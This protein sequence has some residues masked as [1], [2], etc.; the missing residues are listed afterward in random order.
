MALNMDQAVT[1]EASTAAPDDVA[2]VIRKGMWTLGLGFG[3]FLI[4]AAFAPLDEGVPSQA[5]VAVESQRK[6]VQHL[7]GGIVNEVLVKEGQVVKAGDVLFRLDEAS[8][9]ASHEAVRQRYLG[10]RAVQARLL[11]EQKGQSQLI[12][13]PDL[14]T[15]IQDPLISN[16]VNTQQALL[17][18]RHRALKAELQGIEESI[19]G[20]KALIYSYVSMQRS[21]ESQRQFLREELH[22]TRGL[23][24]EG[25]AP[26]NRLLELERQQ[27]E[28][29]TALADLSGR[30]EQ[31]MRTV[32]ELQQRAEVRRYELRKDIE[33]Q[34][35]SVTQDVQA[36]VDRL[37]SLQ[38][39]LSRTEIVSPVTGQAVGVQVQTV[40]GVVQPG[41]KLLDVVPKDAALLLD[42]RIA[43]QLIDKVHAGLN[44]DVRFSAFAHSP[45]LVVQGQV[46]SVSQD[47]L[48]DQQTGIGYYLARVLITPQGMKELGARQMQAGMSAEVVIKTGE[49]TFL[50]YL[51]K[52]LVRRVASSMKEE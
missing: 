14:T 44:A 38:N 12:L 1:Q 37:Q 42:A 25:Y 46:Q 23:V 20:Q 52:P 45:Q 16:Q 31:A 34:L 48:T 4:W 18:A 47:V 11:A 9:K 22:N 33:T 7:M 29:D 36:D 26:R 10:L 21:R 43:P 8:A 51:L 5:V 28:M 41:Q 15:A 30:R 49:R 24:A 6:A 17:L 39:D 19:Q 13:H 3:V 27:A 35:T 50:A 32:A 40:G 2:G